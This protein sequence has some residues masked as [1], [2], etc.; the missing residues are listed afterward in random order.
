[1]LRAFRFRIILL[2]VIVRYAGELGEGAAIPAAGLG[3][4][5]L[6]STRPCE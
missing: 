1:M 5:K 2:G 6:V 4:S 3:S